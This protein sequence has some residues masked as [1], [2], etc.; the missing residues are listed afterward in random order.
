MELIPHTRDEWADCILVIAAAP[1]LITTALK[2]VAINA[3]RFLDM[4]ALYAVQDAW[5]AQLIFVQT[6]V[7]ALVAI[8]LVV[9]KP[10][11]GY[12]AIAAL[13]LSFILLIL[14]PVVTR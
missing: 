3:A 9:I 5:P 8:V 1:L 10:G 6:G 13:L 4:H 11:R 7:L 14:T 2:C 12:W